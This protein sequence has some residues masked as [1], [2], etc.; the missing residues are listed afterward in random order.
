[1]TNSLPQFYSNHL[2]PISL[3]EP[4]LRNTLRILKRAI[5]KGIQIVL[6]SERPGL[7]QPT[8]ATHG[9]IFT[10]DLGKCLPNKRLLLQFKHSFIFNCSGI[11]LTFLRLDYQKAYLEDYDDAPLPDLRAGAIARINS[12]L[13]RL[14]LQPGRP[15]PLESTPL[16]ATVL[17]VLAGTWGEEDPDVIS[18]AIDFAIEQPRCV[19]FRGHLM[20]TDEI[21]YG[22]SGLLW[23]LLEISKRCSTNQ[24][25][26]NSFASVIQQIPRLVNV[27]LEAGKQGAEANRAKDTQSE[28]VWPLMWSWIDGWHSLGAMHGISGILSILIK[29]DL[30]KCYPAIVQEYP[31]I[32]ATITGLCKVCIHNGGHLPMAVP[33]FPSNRSSPMVQL[34]HGVPGLLCL[35]ACAKTNSRFVKEHWTSTWNEAIELGTRV[36]W[37]EGLLS[38]GGGLCHGIAGNALPLLMLADPLNVEDSALVSQ[39]VAMLL[40]AQETRPFFDPKPSLENPNQYRMPDNPYSLFEG[41]SGTICAWAEACIVIEIQLRQKSLAAAGLSD[42]EILVDKEIARLQQHRLGFPC[43]GGQNPGSNPWV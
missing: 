8:N 27:M 22:R 29:P 43:I 19:E 40:A 21:L 24:Q 32:A 13:S 38:K 3:D 18:D 30:E 37:K 12:D 42:E 33:A 36:V 34:C 5:R 41:L 35:L 17:R 39:G 20:G 2:K 16:G 28:D 15:S 14:D 31:A 4:D 23:A 6:S 7:I 25:T 1:M 26:Q 10:G 9:T 11:A